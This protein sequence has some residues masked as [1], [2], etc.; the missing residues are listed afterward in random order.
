VLEA[1]ERHDLGSSEK[2]LHGLARLSHGWLVARPDGALIGV[3]RET[4][5][6]TLGGEPAATPWVSTGAHAY[7][8]SSSG[9]VYRVHMA[10]GR[11]EAQRLAEDTLPPTA[12]GASRR[13]LVSCHGEQV[14]LFDLE[15]HAV[16]TQA[17]DEPVSVATWVGT[18]VAVMDYT[19]RLSL[20]DARNRL[21][22]RGRT[23]VPGGAPASLVVFGE[24]FVVGGSSEVVGLRGRER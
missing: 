11:P 14:R 13:H 16:V 22:V 20:L 6:A 10:G 15:S 5:R 18:H 19:G 24:G 23:R 8:A 12:F 3:A 2:L 17:L 4:G 1:D 21:Q 7:G 9:A